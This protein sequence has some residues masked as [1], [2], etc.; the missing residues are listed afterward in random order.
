MSIHPCPLPG[1][2]GVGSSLL[3]RLLKATLKTSHILPDLDEGRAGE[4]QMDFWSEEK[5]CLHEGVL[6]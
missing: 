1:R 2:S 4:A 6:V 5:T 3:R